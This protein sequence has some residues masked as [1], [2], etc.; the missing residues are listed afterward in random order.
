MGDARRRDNSRSGHDRDNARSGRDHGNSRFGHGRDTPQSG[1]DRD[2]RPRSRS[3]DRRR[4]DRYRDDRHGDHRDDR[5]EEK[6]R[7]FEERKQQDLADSKI[8]W[9]RTHGQEEASGRSESRVQRLE[10]LQATPFIRYADDPALNTRL[11]ATA[12]WDDPARTFVEALKP[13]VQQHRFQPNRF[14]IPPGRQWDGVD[15]SNGFEAKL[16]QKKASTQNKLAIGYRL[17]VENY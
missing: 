14:E 10:D 8:E 17:D 11:K 3:R 6:L 2:R 9:G 13:S 16:F 5:V 4:D 1:H 7:K 15:R 12:R